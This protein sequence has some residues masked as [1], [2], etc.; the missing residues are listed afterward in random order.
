M[1]STFFF[2]FT[3]CHIVYFLHHFT[4]MSAQKGM[5]FWLLFHCIITSPW[6][7]IPS[8]EEVLNKYLLN[9][10]MNEW[11]HL[12]PS[13]FMSV[14]TSM[15]CQYLVYIFVLV[16][17]HCTLSIGICVSLVG[18]SKHLPNCTNPS[19]YS[20]GSKYS[21]IL[22]PLSITASILYSVFLIGSISLTLSIWER[23]YFQL[24]S[25]NLFMFG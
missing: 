19:L 2:F 22:L 24:P 12:L 16:L 20:W 18:L 25:V 13:E 8:T 21:W 23:R 9:E 3:I 15:S 11:N 10:C 7:N 4:R 5:D 14:P 6:K 1:H 17:T